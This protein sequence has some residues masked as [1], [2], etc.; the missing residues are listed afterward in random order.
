MFDRCFT[1]EI[2]IE[3]FKDK[4]LIFKG[5]KFGDLF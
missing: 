1:C 2:F 4:L 3:I 5:K